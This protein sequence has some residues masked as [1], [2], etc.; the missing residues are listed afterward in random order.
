VTVIPVSAA[1]DQA[2]ATARQV[3]QAVLQQQ[4]LR[5]GQRMPVQELVGLS[6]GK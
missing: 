2:G 4:V 3:L 5:Q 1:Q 6:L